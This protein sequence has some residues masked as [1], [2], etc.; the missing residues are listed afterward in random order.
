MHEA[1]STESCLHALQERSELMASH[2]AE[3]EKL[4]EKRS[5][6]EQAFLDRYL[7]AAEDY[8]RQLEA[9]RQADAQDYQTLKIRWAPRWARCCF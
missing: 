4:F 8:H 9:L 6:M 3:M 2:H 5:S 1:V 7:A